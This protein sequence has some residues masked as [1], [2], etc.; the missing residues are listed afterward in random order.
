MNKLHAKDPLFGFP[1]VTFSPRDTEKH[2]NW[3]LIAKPILDPV[4]LKRFDFM[5][6]SMKKNKEEDEYSDYIF[7]T[8]AMGKSIRDLGSLDQIK[9]K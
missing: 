6:K 5:I 9:Q 2:P 1:N 8:F 7:K 3:D 4:Q